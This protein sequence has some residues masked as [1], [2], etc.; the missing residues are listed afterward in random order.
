MQPMRLNRQIG[1]GALLLLLAIAAPRPAQTQIPG[2]PAAT[3]PTA[4]KPPELDPLGRDTPRGCIFGF[5]RAADRGEYTRAAEYLD[6]PPSAAAEER[7]R[8]LQSILNAGFSS[9]LESL[10][11][12]P[13]GNLNDGLPASQELAGTVEVGGRKLDIL[14]HRSQQRSQTPV[15][16][17]SSD[18]LKRVPDTYAELDDFGVERFVPAKLRAV[19]IFSIPLYRWLLTLVE[20]LL[21]WGL[22]GLG[23]RLLFALLRRLVRG[24]DDR[25]LSRLWRPVWLIFL[26]AAFRVIAAVSSTVLG[27]QLW[28]SLTVAMAVIGA[29]WL[30][31][32]ISDIVADLAARRLAR[33]QLESKRAVLSLFHRM[34]KAGVLV[35]G[36]VILIYAS[37]RDVTAILAGVGIGGIAIAF[38]AQ[39]TLENL[40]GG[41]SIISDE[42]IR[43]GDFC[44]FADKL[45]T[46]EDIG[47]RST[48]VRTSD[49][50]LLSIP[51]GQLSQMSLENFTLRDKFLFN[52]KIGLRYETTPAQ[53]Q[54]ILAGIRELLGANAD[55]DQQDARVRLVQFGESAFVIE[56]FGYLLVSD[57]A[58]FFEIQEELLLGILDIIVAGG[59]ELALPSRTMYLS[60]DKPADLSF[61][62]E[63]ASRIRQKGAAATGNSGS[64]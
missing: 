57:G 14:L 32:R 17:I 39:K 27:R 28:I 35:A 34:F 18:T 58:R 59:S 11:R 61:I 53:M 15:W 5:L 56:I 37:G 41:V 3:P 29:G 38:A 9:S 1:A 49:R 16:L 6:M 30:A 10:S 31:M 47:L 45:G 64:S 4:A 24:Q 60:R 19:R 7:A 54:S 46:V 21:A 52:H 25:R 33:H 26:A 43:V 22:A 36:V 55:V 23:S 48:R 8:Q 50:T 44:R 42:P 12:L 20:A 2:Q 63:A 51:N 62:E 40:F 13:E